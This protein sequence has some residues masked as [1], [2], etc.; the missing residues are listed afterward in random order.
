MSS[1][2]LSKPEIE[3]RDLRINNF[4]KSLLILFW[5]SHKDTYKGI[6]CLFKGKKVDIINYYTEE[7]YL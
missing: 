7:F 4:D 6:I 5:S 2:L 1:E 3:K